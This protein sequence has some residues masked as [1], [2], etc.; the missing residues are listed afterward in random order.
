MWSDWKTKTKKK[1]STINKNNQGTG[2]GPSTVRPLNP[3]EERVLRI[4][5]IGSITGNQEVPEAGFEV[6][7]TISICINV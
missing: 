3:L 6:S 2:G 1:A 7:I 4:I 5:G